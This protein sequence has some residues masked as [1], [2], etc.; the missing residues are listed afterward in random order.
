MGYLDPPSLLAANQSTERSKADGAFKTTS[1]ALTYLYLKNGRANR[2]VSGTVRAMLV[3]S[4]RIFLHH[5]RDL[6]SPPSLRSSSDQRNRQID[7]WV[8]TRPSSQG[9][10][11][12]R[13]NPVPPSALRRRKPR[14]S[15]S[16][17]PIDQQAKWTPLGALD[18][19]ARRNH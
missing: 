14:L 10:W 4:T 19:M 15:C 7:R 11:G 9:C 8:L 17:F 13:G 6:C 16:F 1:S 5:P 3:C 18:D 12:S 2:S